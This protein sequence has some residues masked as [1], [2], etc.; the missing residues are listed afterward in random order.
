MNFISQTA[1][2]KASSIESIHPFA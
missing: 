2:A 1:G